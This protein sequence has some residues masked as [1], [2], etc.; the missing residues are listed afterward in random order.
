MPETKDVN[1]IM[2]KRFLTGSILAIVLVGCGGSG[3]SSGTSLVYGVNAC[4][5]VG[6]LS[7]TAN[8]ALVL[9]NA[10][11]AATSSAFVGV[12]AGTNATIFLTNASSTQLASGSTTL[13]TNAYYTAFAIGNAINQYIFIY[14]TDVA[15]PTAGFGKLI[16]V[17][18]SI[19]QP[20]VD[21]YVTPSGGTQ[22]PPVLTSMTPFNSGVEPATPL[23]AGTYDVQFKVAGTTTLLLDEPSVVIGTTPTSNEIQIVG[24]TDSQTGAATL[25]AALP[26]IPVPVIVGATPPRTMGRPVVVGHPNMTEFPKLTK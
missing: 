24:I 13:T 3:G 6:A 2:I 15:P 7:I 16:F 23:A 25:Q 14:P 17:N 19:L 4:P 10:A 26:V 21:V 20:S 11:Y 12:N 18:S 5:N 22:G 9:N 8:G 1:K